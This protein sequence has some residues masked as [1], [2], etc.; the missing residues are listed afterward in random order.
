[1]E[2][3]RI[4]CWRDG[5]GGIKGAELKKLARAAGC[6]DGEA[7]LWRHTAWTAGLLEVGERNDYG[8][9]RSRAR[10][11]GWF[12]TIE[13]LQPTEDCQAWRQSGPADRL[14]V[15]VSAWA[16]SEYGSYRSGFSGAQGLLETGSY[17]RKPVMPSPAPVSR[18]TTSPAMS[19]L[20]VV[21]MPYGRM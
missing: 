16:A 4:E 14:A 17:P 15:L 9:P 2:A 18:Q 8:R 13:W 12:D 1:L 3:T 7:R 21:N 20:N 10:R 11:G 19:K 6:S 5:G